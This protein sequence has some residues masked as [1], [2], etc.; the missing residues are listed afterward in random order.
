MYVVPDA[1]RQSRSSRKDLIFTPRHDQHL[2]G[3][4]V[5]ILLLWTQM[6]VSSIANLT[7]HRWASTPSSSYP[8]RGPPILRG[9]HHARLPRQPRP[10]LYQPRPMPRPAAPSFPV[11]PRV[12]SRGRAYI[13]F[14]QSRQLHLVTAEMGHAWILENGYLAE[15]HAEGIQWTWYRPGAPVS[16][17]VMPMLAHRPPHRQGHVSGSRPVIG[18]PEAPVRPAWAPRSRRYED[19]RRLPPTGYTD[20]ALYPVDVFGPL[21]T[22]TY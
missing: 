9:Y 21:K 12:H 14:T 11:R 17:P 22:T 7:S 15:K 20:H 10:A 6:I 8:T 1:A 18:Y 2:L 19:H 16:R 13:Q 3:T 5:L 4:C